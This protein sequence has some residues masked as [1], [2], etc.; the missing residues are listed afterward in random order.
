[1][2]LSA[3]RGRF[4]GVDAEDE[5]DDFNRVA[6]REGEAEGLIDSSCLMAATRAVLSSWASSPSTDSSRLTSA[7]APSFADGAGEVSL[8]LRPMSAMIQTIWKSREMN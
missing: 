3:P 8:L 4:E 2:S 1:V 7:A 6:L 5:R